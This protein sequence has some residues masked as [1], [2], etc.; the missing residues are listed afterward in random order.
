MRHCSTC[1]SSRVPWPCFPTNCVLLLCCTG[2][3]RLWS[4]TH[5]SRL[6]LR[7]QRHQTARPPT[8]RHQQHLQQQQTTRKHNS[9]S[10][11]QCRFQNV[12]E[13]IRRTQVAALQPVNR[14]CA[15][16]LL[17]QRVGPPHRQTAAHWFACST[18]G[19][20][21]EPSLKPLASLGVL[22]RF[23]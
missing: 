14:C 22:M 6:N 11:P 10:G 15:L 16:L 20:I 3:G 7:S 5:P 23:R 21:S 17:R 18:A 1:C 9:P 2:A 19:L 8:A 13:Y 12:Q 4:S